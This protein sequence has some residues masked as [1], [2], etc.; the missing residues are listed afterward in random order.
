MLSPSKLNSNNSSFSLSDTFTSSGG[1]DKTRL[2]GLK[3]H[4]KVHFSSSSSHGGTKR[5]R[6]EGAESRFS[7]VKRRDRSEENG[8]DKRYSQKKPV[9]RFAEKRKRTLKG[10]QMTGRGAVKK[11]SGGQV[12]RRRAS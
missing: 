7:R 1:H 12:F 4:K 6:T 8:G 3:R 5:R 2:V 10:K 11:Q 9:V